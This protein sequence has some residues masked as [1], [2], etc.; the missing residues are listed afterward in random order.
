MDDDG[1]FAILRRLLHDRDV[2]L[3]D[4]FVGSVLLLYGKPITQI[5]ALRTTAINVNGD[6]H[7]RLTL[8]R[9]A[10]RHAHHRRTL[11]GRLKRYGIGRSREGA[12]RAPRA[13]RE[14]A[15]AD[16]R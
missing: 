1:R 2:D 7:R 14:I 8:P 4:R 15:R 16:P 6:G 12:R 11:R 9:P 10:R 13:S 5:A 3:R